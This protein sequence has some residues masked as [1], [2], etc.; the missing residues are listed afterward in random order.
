MARSPRRNGFCEPAVGVTSGRYYRTCSQD[1]IGS[2]RTFA[3][4]TASLLQGNARR[5]S[6]RNGSGARITR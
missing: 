2:L 3:A 6:Q 1:P 4:F 5:A